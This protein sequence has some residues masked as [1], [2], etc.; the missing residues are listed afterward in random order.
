MTRV[1][2]WCG[3]D[4]APKTE[5]AKH[6][7]N[8]ITHGIC[9]D[10]VDAVVTGMSQDLRKFLNTIEVPVLTTNADGV[11]GSANRSAEQLLGRSLPNIE[12]QMVGTVTECTYARL[13]GGC[14]RTEHCT[15]CTLREAIDR[16]VQTGESQSQV[17]VHQNVL[18]GK[19]TE[20]VTYEISTHKVKDVVFL[21]IQ[22]TGR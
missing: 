11:V 21:K 17:P 20:T 2:A 13:P 3:N 18:N 6:T 12:G 14:R 22:R 8:S 15:A 7:D 19:G 5:S 16:T 10:C 4:L 9:E 1:C